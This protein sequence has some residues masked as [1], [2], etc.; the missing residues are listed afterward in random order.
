MITALRL[1]AILIW[2]KMKI[3]L[4]NTLKPKS[5]FLD[6][7]S[8]GHFSSK[9]SDVL[10]DR[11]DGYFQNG[12]EFP[13]NSASSLTFKG[14]SSEKILQTSENLMSSLRNAYLKHTVQGGFEISDYSK[15]VKNTNKA[16]GSGFVEGYVNEFRRRMGPKSSEFLEL[17][18]NKLVVHD[19]SLPGKLLAGLLDVAKLPID[20][21]GAMV[22]GLQK[23]P[24]VK[25][26]QI[27]KKLA[28]AS[29]LQNRKQQKETMEL[30]YIIKGFGD[31]ASN[32]EGL[33]KAILKVP[34]GKA[35]GNYNTKD[36]RALNRL[37]TGLVSS[38]FVGT[39]FYNLVMY[40]KNNEKE[41]KEAGNKR[42]KREMMRIGLSAFMTYTVLG[43][44]SS[45]VNKSKALACA[46][47]AGSSLF[48][49]VVTRLVAGVPLVPL[50]PE[51]AKEYNKKQIKK[52]K[53]PLIK[54]NSG[55]E[56]YKGISLMPENNTN[57]F[58]N[59]FP[60]TP[61]G[62][63]ISFE[64]AKK[65]SIKTDDKKS[66]KNKNPIT[67]KRVGLAIGAAFAFDIL[68]G[69][70]RSKSITF[71]NFIKEA[72]KELRY[73]YDRNTKKE[74][75]LSTKELKRFLRGFDNNNLDGVKKS[76]EGI[77]NIDYNKLKRAIGD[78]QDGYCTIKDKNLINSLYGQ[79]DT[80]VDYTMYNI[81]SM[82][83]KVKEIQK[84]AKC[85]TTRTP[86]PD[87]A[88]FNFG[89]VQEKKIRALTDAIL[90]P[91][92]AL[93]SLI[94]APVKPLLALSKKAAPVPPQKA[95]GDYADIAE[96]YHDCSTMYK[97]YLKGKISMADFQEY[98]RFVNTKPLNTDT[99]AKYPQTALASI[100]R[101]FVTLI[102]SYFF[103]NDFRN[104]ILIQSNGENTQ[105]A[106]E[107]TKERTAHKLSNYVLNKFFM[108]L[109][110]NTFRK[111]YLGS[112]AGATAV[113]AATEL[114]NES[115]VRLSIGV[116]LD[117]KSSRDE[118]DEYEKK[119]VE[120]KGVIGA[121]YR[122][123]A[124]ITGKKML[125]EKAEKK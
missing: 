87:S 71:D 21:Y 90:Y 112:L 93:K 100:S 77:F 82:T 86:I 25:N 109:F 96:L 101:N 48:S 40:E 113:A 26:T 55:P 28:D 24:K 110:N 103:I 84:G 81:K 74:L 50:T 72:S 54:N 66:D 13:R 9:I 92:K 64:D 63:D 85:G 53:N 58:A 120:K 75:I 107:V 62:K 56:A 89:R 27:V 17:N 57:V 97:K 117:K 42:V 41:A 95:K 18:N 12:V 29:F 91:L 123:M 115:S 2:G 70:A 78:V 68:Y 116:P 99:S 102:S 105:K 45:Y 104:E 119:H 31:Y 33:K 47:I 5:A 14:I 118:I 94:K 73:F 125:S 69:I 11:Q 114:T 76:Y 51:G 46:A 39:D 20:I 23:I 49:E 6:A 1:D 15:F 52:G 3:G 108:E 60:N 4:I 124:R 111:Q 43:S 19:K 88:V 59:K 44:L 67:L 121:Y 10:A 38:L 34:A 98:V 7:K 22:G 16:M 79:E 122:L 30:F 8:N 80:T 61:A 106:S 36:E 65:N 83:V 32:P 37:A 35:V